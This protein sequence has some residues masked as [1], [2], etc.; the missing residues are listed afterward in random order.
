[1][2]QN[3]PSFSSSSLLR[4]VT[5]SAGIAALAL[6]AAC[7]PTE[8]DVCPYNCP[9]DYQAFDAINANLLTSD[10]LPILSYKVPAGTMHV[11]RDIH[12]LDNDQRIANV[13]R[14]LYS[15]PS[16]N[17]PE[18]ELR[19]ILAGSYLLTPEADSV[20]LNPLV[21]ELPASDASQEARDRCALAQRNANNGIWKL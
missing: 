7:T 2:H 8:R 4:S 18:G 14:C 1:M 20:I 3:K 6:A 16:D 11:Y 10:T 19:T 13:Q 15:N 17:A 12:L 5:K 21:H 9:E